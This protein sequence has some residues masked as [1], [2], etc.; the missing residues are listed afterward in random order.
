LR[1]A[2][3]SIGVYPYLFR[4][5]GQNGAILAW[6]MGSRQAKRVRSRGSAAQ[7]S[8]VLDEVRRLVSACSDEM[9]LQNAVQHIRLSAEVPASVVL[10]L[11]PL[12]ANL[13]QHQVADVLDRITV[14]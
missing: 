11:M 2:E 13:P 7:V 6:A 9:V 8:A 14:R 12:V 10:W 5:T 1:V 4:Q 3:E